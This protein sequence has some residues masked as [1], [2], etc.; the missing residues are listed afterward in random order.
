MTSNLA[1]EEPIHADS[2]VDGEECWISNG[3]SGF[4]A[5]QVQLSKQ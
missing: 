3:V 4:I 5:A 1:V 2:L